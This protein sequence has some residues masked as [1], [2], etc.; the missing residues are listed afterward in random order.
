VRHH[1]LLHAY[2]RLEYLD[3]RG[4]SRLALS[5]FSSP[6]LRV[7]RLGSGALPG[8]VVRA[9]SASGLPRLQTLELWLGVTAHG[10]NVTIGDLAGILS[11]KRL[12][13][14]AGERAGPAAAAAGAG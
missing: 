13:A 6:A 3:V 10:G 8:T 14:L 12:P 11:G 2:P 4:G 1:P 9:V 5:P 7:L